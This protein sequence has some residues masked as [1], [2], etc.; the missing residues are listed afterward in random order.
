MHGLREQVRK[1]ENGGVRIDKKRRLVGAV[2]E[3][4][5][6]PRTFFF[7]SINIFVVK[8][9]YIYSKNR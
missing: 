9:F 1:G 8:M 2:K 6:D 3:G 5:R 7:F 4:V